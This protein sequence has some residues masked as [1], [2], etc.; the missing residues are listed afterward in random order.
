MMLSK[1]KYGKNNYD[2]LEDKELIKVAEK[3]I[4]EAKILFFLR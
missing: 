4:D 1:S 3:I 2:D